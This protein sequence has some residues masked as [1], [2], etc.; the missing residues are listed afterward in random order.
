MHLKMFLFRL[1]LCPDVKTLK[2]S[3]KDRRF[4]HAISK[5][6][7]LCGLLSD[8]PWLQYFHAL[9]K[10]KQLLLIMYINI[11]AVLSLIE[12][13]GAKTLL[14]ALLFRAISAS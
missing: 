2:P 5:M 12:A 8:T 13:P 9:N 14:R 3:Q 6:I 1:A 11:Y 7:F 4:A 10:I